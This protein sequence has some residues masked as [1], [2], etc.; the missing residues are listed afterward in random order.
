V[1]VKLIK[2]RIEGPC[3]SVDESVQLL[4]TRLKGTDIPSSGLLK[5]SSQ[6]E[7]L[8]L[9]LAQGAAYIREMTI[10]VNKYL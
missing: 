7:H 3:M 1:G 6:L 8:P 4:C 2:G 9:A 10:T 5:L